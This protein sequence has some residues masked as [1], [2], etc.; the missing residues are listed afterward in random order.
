[1]RLIPFRWL[2]PAGAGGRLSIF[3]FHRVLACPDP[4]RPSEPDADRFATIVKF[5]TSHFQVLTLTEAVDALARG[6]LPAAAACITFD[7]GYADNLTVAAPILRRYGAGA[8]VFVATAFIDGGRMWNDS[9]IEAVRAIPP[10]EADWEDLGLGRSLITD[11]GSRLELVNRTLEQLKYRAATERAEIA[12]ELMQRAGATRASELMLSLSQ[13]AE[14]RDQ[15]FEVGGHTVHHPILAR[16]SEKEAAAEIGVGREQLAQ[17]LGEA[18]TVFAYPNGV[19]GR[20]YGQRDIELVKQAGY[21]SAVS[22][23]RG[24]ATRHADLYQLPRFT[25]WDRSMW[26]FGLRC[27]Q[28]LVQS[29]RAW[30][31]TGRSEMEVL[32]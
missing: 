28:T 10:G 12:G 19:C 9:V 23:M 15:G 17:W 32:T 5:I 11:D 25:P 13:L 2:A 24:A 31:Q 20:D 1:V 29:R 21:S 8:T 3:I 26:V 7:D 16:L 22:T 30:R 27:A 14:W 6:R 4:L 18:P